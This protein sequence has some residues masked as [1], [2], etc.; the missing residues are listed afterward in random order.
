[1]RLRP[2]RASV[3]ALA[4][5]LALG[6]CF[7]QPEPADPAA[8]TTSSATTSA[9]TTPTSTPRPTPDKPVLPETAKSSDAA[10]QEAFVRY[11]FTTFDYAIATG[12]TEPMMAIAHENCVCAYMT[13]EV[14][15]IYDAGGH[16]EGGLHQNIVVEPT[17]LDDSNGAILHVTFIQDD[18]ADVF[19]D[20][21]REDFPAWKADRYVYLFYLDGNWEFF[22]LGEK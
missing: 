20:G 6:G 8:T 5:A 18:G 2:A 22:G 17:P 13:D 9:S 21:R 10:G 14:H 19:P 12:D 3:I 15:R 1:M 16:V 4:A 11:W 7:S